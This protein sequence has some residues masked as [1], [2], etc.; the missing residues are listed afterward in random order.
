MSALLI[1]NYDITDPERLEA[2]RA[3]AG[4]ALVGE[5]GGRLVAVSHDTVD[6]GEGRPTGA[7]TVILEF[8]SLDAA[9]TA[10]ESEQYQAIIGERLAA[11][12]PKFAIIVPGVDH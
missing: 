1:I 6:L 5:G 4:A 7:T 11:T 8:A 2:Y 12:D 10:F 3:P 9:Q